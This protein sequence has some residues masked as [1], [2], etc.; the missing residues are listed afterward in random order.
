MSIDRTKKKA[1]AKPAADLPAP[2]SIVTRLS[3]C[4]RKNKVYYTMKNGNNLPEELW[5]HG[6]WLKIL[7]NLDQ[8]GRATA[9]DDI[10]RR[11][12]KHGILM[13]QENKVI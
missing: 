4:P 7:N 10:L 3:R 12:Q 2:A 5:P 13:P 8:E 9:Y 11:A 1:A 6:L